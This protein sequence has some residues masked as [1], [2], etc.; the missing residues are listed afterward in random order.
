MD[1]YLYNQNTII[2]TIVA[3]TADDG[4]HQWIV[5]GSVTPG[6]AYRVKVGCRAV[7]EAFGF[8]GTF[9]IATP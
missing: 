2:S 1:I 9:T 7:S 6:T 4:A 8:S 5:P 3:N